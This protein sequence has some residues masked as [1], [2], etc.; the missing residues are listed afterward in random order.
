MAAIL[1]HSFAP[2]PLKRPRGREQLFQHGNGPGPVKEATAVR[3]M[4]GLG[5]ISDGCRV[6]GEDKLLVID[7]EGDERLMLFALNRDDADKWRRKSRL[8]RAPA[9]SGL[10]APVAPNSPR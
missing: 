1:G 3:T 8:R 4:L 9:V 5:E 6:L 7:C 10:A 2:L